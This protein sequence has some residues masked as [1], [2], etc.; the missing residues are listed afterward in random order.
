MPVVNIGR[1]DY[2]DLVI[3]DDSVSSAH[4]KLQRREGVWVLFDNES[5]NGTWVDGERVTDEAMLG[6]GAMVRFGE[7]SLMFEPTDDH[8][9]TGSGSG[10]KVMGA[11]RLASP[12]PIPAPQPV[13]S[14][15]PSPPDAA[16]PQAPLLV[17]VAKAPGAAAIAASR[18]AP[19][20]PS[21]PKAPAQSGAEPPVPRSA[22]RRPPVGVSMPTTKGIPGWIVPAV[23]I[24]LLGV[25]AAILL[26]R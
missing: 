22:P 2:N 10:T 13:A 12:P 20:T 9:G 14:A 21:E 23:L 4:A 24:V 7:V 11:V 18:A 19:P 5:T 17:P 15:P 6:P 1:A 3:P 8:L 16:P 25:V 26:L